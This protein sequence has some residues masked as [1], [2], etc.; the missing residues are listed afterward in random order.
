[1]AQ[2]SNPNSFQKNLKKPISFGSSFHQSEYSIL[3]KEYF[4]VST[5]L[6]AFFEKN[7]CIVK[8]CFFSLNNE[9][10]FTTLFLSFLILRRSKKKRKIE[11]TVDQ[12]IKTSFVVQKFLSILSKFGYISS[13]R[14]V[15]QNLNKVALKYQKTFFAN[16]HFQIQKEFMPFR[17]EIYYVPGI[18]L[19]CLMNTTKNTSSLLSKFIARFFKIFHR[20]KNLN[21][22]LFFLSKFVESIDLIGFKDQIKGLKIQISG[23]FK[24]EPRTKTRIFEK[25]QIPLQTISNN[26]SYSLTHVHT[27][28]GVFGI[29]V[30]VFE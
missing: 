2:K 1:M 7:N 20:T 28:Y 11:S 21:K 24:G 26:I 3:L 25:G 18:F 22:F 10:S 29:K 6:I 23:R 14:L 19:F 15:L 12:Q 5:N 9:K 16:E 13:K 4:T 17:K 27:S 30:W 8:N